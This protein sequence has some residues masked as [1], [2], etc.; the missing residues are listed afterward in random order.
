MSG[1]RGVTSEQ[2]GR[3][4][5]KQKKLLKSIKFP[6]NFSTRLDMGKVQVRSACHLCVSRLVTFIASCSANPADLA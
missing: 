1:F 3:F 2:D 4:G 5:D 6:D